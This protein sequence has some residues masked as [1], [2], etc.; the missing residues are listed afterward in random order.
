MVTD[1]KGNS[2]I[3][4]GSNGEIAMITPAGALNWSNNPNGALSPTYE[5]WHEALNCDQTQLMVSGMYGVGTPPN[6]W[7]GAIMNI[8]LTNGSIANTK[9][10]GGGSGFT[11]DECRS[12]CFAPNGN[13]YFLTLDSVGSINPA[14]TTYGFKTNSTYNF[15]YGSPTYAMVGNMGLN[16]MHATKNFLYT[17]NGS[18]VAQ[19]SIGSGTI[20]ASAAIPG[21]SASSGLGTYSPN[22]NGIDIDSC[23]NVYVGSCNS[24]TEFTAGLAKVSTV[25]TPDS[26][27]DVA[28]NN[29]GEV[30]ACGK[31]FAMSINFSACKPFA[32][33]CHPCTN[34]TITKT[35]TNPLCNGSATG[36]ATVNASGGGP[37]Y[38]NW[39]NGDT[40]ATTNNLSA[41][42][43]T[44]TVT[45]TGGCSISDTL[46]IKQPKALNVGVT[47]A[48]SCSGSNGTATATVTGGTG[49]YTYK[50]TPSGGTNVTATGL[51]A[52]TY[53]CTV[54]DKNGCT[55]TQTATVSSATGSGPTVNYVKHKC[56]LWFMQRNCYSYIYSLQEYTVMYGQTEILLKL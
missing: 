46:T 3:T 2:Y 22:N 41:G 49:P 36:S 43:Y 25:S 24:V 19:R 14:L 21:G 10:V 47:S 18:N 53:T 1:R 54:T 39:S 28:V 56:S 40:T 31:G 32:P 11:I 7:R 16:A 5:Y 44:I 29:N 9:I 45:N 20:L 8:N 13:Y 42:T 23:G 34:P 35:T 52:G 55:Q 48:P 26:V 15:S 17:V 37:Y 51:A 33:I 50:W 12:I 6:G 27:Y 30:V 38:F 4:S